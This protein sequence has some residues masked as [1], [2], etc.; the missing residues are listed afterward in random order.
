MIIR[1]NLFAETKAVYSDQATTN[2][3]PLTVFLN[4]KYANALGLYDATAKVFDASGANVVPGFTD[5]A[6]GDFT[7]SNQTLKDNLV[8]DPRWIK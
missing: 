7:I 4:N 1:N 5:P 8:G 3:A 2:P 6:T